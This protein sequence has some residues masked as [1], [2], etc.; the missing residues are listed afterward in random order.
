MDKT[1][2]DGTE[3]LGWKR[4]SDK[5][6][7]FWNINYQDPGLKKIFWE[8]YNKEKN[9]YLSNKECFNRAREY[10]ENKALFLGINIIYPRDKKIGEKDKK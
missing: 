10:T 9:N 4:Y 8:K 3:L 2:E 5:K 7:K 6:G 1:I